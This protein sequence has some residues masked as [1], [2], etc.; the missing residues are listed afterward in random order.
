MNVVIYILVI[1]GS[2]VLAIYPWWRP[3]KEV[4]V[5]AKLV[6]SVGPL[7]AVAWAVISIV[8]IQHQTT[9]PLPETTSRQLFHL[10]A[11]AG[12]CAIGLLLPGLFVTRRSKGGVE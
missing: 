1:L 5:P 11:F 2:I 10:K 9:D 6:W 7:C 4:C 12:G 3:V 8:L